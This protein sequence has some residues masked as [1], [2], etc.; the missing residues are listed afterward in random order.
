MVAA[1]LAA[2]ADIDRQ[3]PSPW[4]EI[5]LAEELQRDDGFL[6][7]ICLGE[8]VAGWGCLRHSG[9]EAELLKITVARTFRRQKLGSCLFDYLLTSLEQ[10][11]V[12]ALFLEV[13]SCNRPALSFYRSSGFTD[14]GRR[15]NYYR[16]PSD[17][18]LILRKPLLPQ[19]TG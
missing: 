18:A 8:T 3:E 2:V 14:V 7:V 12:E 17:D 1:D 11:G 16:Q 13:R 15:I 4:S 5:A 10:H 9:Y 19:Q 6:A